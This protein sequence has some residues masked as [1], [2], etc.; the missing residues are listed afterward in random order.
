MNLATEAQNRAPDVKVTKSD[1]EN[2]GRSKAVPVPYVA[3]VRIKRG[4]KGLPRI[5]SSRCWALGEL[6]RED[7]RRSGN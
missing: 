4:F 6:S 3:S 1:C 5:S 7:G 2:L